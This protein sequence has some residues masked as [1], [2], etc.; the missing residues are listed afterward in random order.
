MK[1]F[2]TVKELAVFLGSTER[3]VWQ[4]I[5]RGQLPCRRWGKRV[6]IPID[7]LEKFLEAL[8]GHTAEQALDAVETSRSER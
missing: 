8:P 1:K 4:R 5:Y 3:A 2:L 6:L 7:E